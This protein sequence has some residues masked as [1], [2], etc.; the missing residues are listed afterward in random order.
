MKLYI[1]QTIQIHLIKIGSVSNSSVFQI[2]TLGAVTE[3]SNLYNT[4]GYTQPAPP[5]KKPGTAVLEPGEYIKGGEK[6]FVPF[7][8]AGT[9]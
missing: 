4:G 3:T 7:A 5:A 1:Q 9:R 6:T 8:P 2:G